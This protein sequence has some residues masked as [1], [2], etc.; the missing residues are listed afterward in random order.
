M[1]SFMLCLVTID[2]PRKA[3]QIATVLVEKKLAACVNIVPEIRSIYNWKGQLC[4]ETEKLL[5]IK[6]RSELFEDLKATVVEL[7][8]Y[9]VP[10]IISVPI[11]QGLGSYLDWIHDSTKPDA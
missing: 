9:E 4:D 10:E 7:H 2:D 6:S 8:P 3:A 11:Q 5:I 1:E